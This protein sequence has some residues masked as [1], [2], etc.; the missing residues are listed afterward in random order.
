MNMTNN[1]NIPGDESMFAEALV[2]NRVNEYICSVWGYIFRC[3]DFKLFLSVIVT[4]LVGMGASYA[5]NTVTYTELDSVIDDTKKLEL[6]FRGITNEDNQTRISVELESVNTPFSIYKAEWVNNDSTFMPLENFTLSSENY[7]VSNKRTQWHISIDFPFSDSFQETDNILLYT[8]RGLVKCPTS[9]EGILI[10]SIN[11]LSQEYS[12][13]IKSS[14]QN[15]RYWRWALLFSV[16]ILSLICLSVFGVMRRRILRKHREIEEL[17]ML[18]SERNDRN[19]E[20]EAKVN[21]L[22]GSRLDTLNMLCNEYFE[23]ND[24]GNLRLTLYNEV[25]KHILSLRDNKSIHDL[26]ALV[27]KYLD[28]ILVRLK[29]QLPDL[30]SKDYHFLTYLYAGFSP[31]AVCVFTDIKIKNFYNR[32]SRLKER[33]MKSDAPDK[34]FFVSK[35]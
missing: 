20:L 27:N 24:S 17:S 14:E 33:I 21:E 23:K 19:K 16:C 29:E 26:E 13:K 7:E 15:T 4:L 9:R 18:I 28:N 2:N 22:Y 8:D 32:R 34:V 5:T 35:M 11:L 6:R 31:R 12:Q 30:N 25:E 1:I 3:L 10:E